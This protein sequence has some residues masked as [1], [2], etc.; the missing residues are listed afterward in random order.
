MALNADSF[1]R[2]ILFFNDNTAYKDEK[3]IVI[4]NKLN[5]KSSESTSETKLG[6]AAIRSRFE[7][8]ADDNIL[9]LN[10]INQIQYAI[11]NERGKLIVKHHYKQSIK[12]NYDLFLYATKNRVNNNIEYFYDN[13]M[14]QLDENNE[15]NENKTKVLFIN[16]EKTKDIE[17]IE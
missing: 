10:Q 6:V 14:I 13:K 16:K 1:I 8:K 9:N 3:N 15:N 17:Y 11:M 5:E 4:F 12:N 2:Y 7:Q